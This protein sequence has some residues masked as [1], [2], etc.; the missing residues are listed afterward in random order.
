MTKNEMTKNEMPRNGMKES[1][2]KQNLKKLNEGFWFNKKK[3]SF[4]F[5]KSFELAS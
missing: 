3:T 1:K 2:I 4:N 5:I